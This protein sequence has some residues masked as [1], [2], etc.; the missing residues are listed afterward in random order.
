MHF[1]R[2]TDALDTETLATIVDTAPMRITQFEFATASFA[3]AFWWEVRGVECAARDLA[4][5]R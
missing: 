5:S 1:F 3:M 2:E 4:Q